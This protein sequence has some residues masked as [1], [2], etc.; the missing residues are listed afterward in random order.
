MKLIDVTTFLEVMKG[1]STKPILVAALNEKGYLG[2][3]VVKLYKEKHERSA[4]STFKELIVNHLANEFELR[5]PNCFLAKIPESLIQSSSRKVIQF[6]IENIENYSLNERKLSLEYVKA[7]TVG[8]NDQFDFDISIYATIYAL[9]FFIFNVDRGGQNNK[10]NLM[11]DDEGFLLIDHELTFNFLNNAN[12]DDAREDLHLDNSNLHSDD[13]IVFER[14]KSL[15]NMKETMYNCRQ[16]LFFNKL[17]QD[18][19][20]KMFDDFIFLLEDISMIKFKRYIEE[21]ENNGIKCPSSYLLIEYVKFVQENIASFE[22]SLY[23]S[24]LK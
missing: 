19:N 10:P 21:L 11:I 24:L 9:D 18:F 5:T 12:F 20:P 2:H 15:I 1:G 22:A 17:K 16:H 8:F 14:I 4:Y 7:S 13:L 23:N 3:Y 6:K